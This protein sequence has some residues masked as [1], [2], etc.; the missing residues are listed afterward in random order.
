MAAINCVVPLDIFSS[1]TPENAANWYVAGPIRLE[2][3]S[4]DADRSGSIIY[5]RCVEYGNVANSG[6]NIV[7]CAAA[8]RV[9]VERKIIT[10]TFRDMFIFSTSANIIRYTKILNPK[11]RKSMI[12]RV[13]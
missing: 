8:A 13:F 7:S 11:S 9:A 6:V 2:G 4:P 3:S 5:C 1:V 12:S 10:R